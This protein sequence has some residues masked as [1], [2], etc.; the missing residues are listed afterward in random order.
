MSSNLPWKEACFSE[1]VVSSR[2]GL[3]TWAVTH[4]HFAVFL[5]LHEGFADGGSGKALNQMN[6]GVHY[7]SALLLPTQGPS[8]SRFPRC[9]GHVKCSV[10]HHF[11][12]REDREHSNSVFFFTCYFF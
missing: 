5:D 1:A 10:R 9:A 11:F 12:G 3:P 8:Q 4:S 6:C 2:P 7:S